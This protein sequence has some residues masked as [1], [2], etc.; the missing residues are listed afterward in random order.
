[1]TTRRRRP[2]Q[3]QTTTTTTKFQTNAGEKLPKFDNTADTYLG[4]LTRV[5]NQLAF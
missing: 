2:V 3:Q 4:H 1:M 5:N